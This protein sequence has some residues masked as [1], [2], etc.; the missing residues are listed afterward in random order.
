LQ[1]PLELVEDFDVVG[2]WR[3]EFPLGAAVDVGVFERF[4]QIVHTEGYVPGGATTAL[5][6]GFMQGS[7]LPFQDPPR[8]YMYFLGSFTQGFIEE[9][10]PDLVPGQD[11]SFF[12][13]PTI[14]PEFA[15]ATTGGADVVVA[16]NGSDVNCGGDDDSS[17]TEDVSLRVTPDTV[18]VRGDEGV[19]RTPGGLRGLEVGDE[20]T[21]TLSGDAGTREV[22][23]KAGRREAMSWAPAMRELRRLRMHAPQAPGMPRLDEEIRHKMHRAMD[24]IH[25]NVNRGWGRVE[26]APLNE[27]L[28]RYFGADQ[29]VLVVS[30]PE[31]NPLGLKG[32]DVILRIGEREPNDPGHAFRIARSYGVGETLEVEI[33]R[34][35]DRRTL[36]HELDD[37]WD[38]DLGWNPPGAPEAFAF[39][40]ASPQGS[41]D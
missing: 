23:V 4:G 28:G 36:T 2:D 29:G 31:D 21:L 25:V 19:F 5:A 20:V 24:A 34:D 30:A 27:D 37:E 22:T 15:G 32:G 9:Q 12:D 10:F 35:G 11:Y 16:F 38:R 14:N 33:L 18:D 1:I 3:V 17:S 6:T 41:P 26:L 7:Y 13:F 40:F 39:G 8:A